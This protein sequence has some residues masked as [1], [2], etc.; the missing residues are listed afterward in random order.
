VC[1]LRGQPQI[2][3]EVRLA[4]VDADGQDILCK[5][6][7]AVELFSDVVLDVDRLESVRCLR[8]RDRLEPS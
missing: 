2:V 6:T 7:L 5:L 4:R 8:G 3:L 1:L